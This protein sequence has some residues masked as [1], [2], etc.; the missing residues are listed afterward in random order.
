MLLLSKPRL[1]PSAPGSGPGALR[2][3]RRCLCMQ[4]AKPHAIEAQQ[5][6]DQRQLQNA[7]FQVL[8]PLM[9][10]GAYWFVGADAL[11]KLAEPPRRWR[12]C[13]AE[14]SRKR[15]GV[16]YP[17]S[18]KAV[19]GGNEKA[20]RKSFSR[21]AFRMSG[22]LD[23]NQ[24]PPEP[25]SGGNASQLPP[26]QAHP[27]SDPGV[28]TPVCTSE[29]ATQQNDPVTAIAAALLGLSPADRARL[30]AL[31]VGQQPGQSEAKS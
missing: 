1:G 29:G 12:R 2:D 20:R 9:S 25:H 23:S 24:R 18:Y 28:C 30:A 11:A 8:A 26:A 10:V 21:R 17:V 7:S 6:Q 22:R 15:W 4:P 31:L 3:S 5:V 13:T 27:G 14:E 16:S 19:F